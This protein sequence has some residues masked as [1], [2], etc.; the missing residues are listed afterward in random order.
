[1]RRNAEKFKNRH[2]QIDRCIIENTKKVRPHEMRLY[3]E[4]Q[5]Q[6]FRKEKKT[7]QVTRERRSKLRMKDI[8]NA[9]E[10][11]QVESAHFDWWFEFEVVRESQAKRTTGERETRWYIVGGET[12]RCLKKLVNKRVELMSANVDD[13]KATESRSKWNARTK[14]ESRHGK[15]DEN[16]SNERLRA[17]FGIQV[18]CVWF[19]CVTLAKNKSTILGTN[20]HSERYLKKLKQSK[21]SRRQRKSGVWNQET[22]GEKQEKLTNRTIENWS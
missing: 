8:S 4:S 18:M 11:K 10:N 3:F 19:S 14:D 2:R 17:R 13:N 15:K 1:M 7:K 9:N 6:W 12:M 16:D 5:K 22:P 21:L 20:P